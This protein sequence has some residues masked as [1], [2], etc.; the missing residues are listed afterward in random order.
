MPVFQCKIGTADGRV[1]EREFEATDRQALLENLEEQGF[2]VF[3]IRR[4]SLRGLFGAASGARLSGRR[5]LSLNQE[6]LVLIRSGLPILQALD[7]LIE[8][9]EAGRL[10]ETLREIRNDV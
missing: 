9:M 8:R 4:A 6:L 1:L 10:L 3:Q 7:T 5:F 2:F